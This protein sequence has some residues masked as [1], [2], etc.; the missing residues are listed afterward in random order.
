MTLRLC[1]LR[2]RFGG[3]S[4]PDARL[5]PLEDGAILRALRSVSGEQRSPIFYPIVGMD[6]NSCEEVKDFYNLH[7]WEKGFGIRYGRCRRNGNKYR[8]RQD[9]VCSCEVKYV[10]TYLFLNILYPLLHGFICYYNFH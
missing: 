4:G 9:F 2:R 6:F 1:S 7:S 8:L 3:I 5:E 10:F